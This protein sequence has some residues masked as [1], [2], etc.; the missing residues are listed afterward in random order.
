VE[1]HSDVWVAALIRR[2]ELGGGFATVARKGDPRSGAVLVKTLAGRGGAARL[3]AQAFSGEGEEVWM[4]P[5]D[6]GAEADVD[7]YA[8][9]AARIDPDIWVVEIEHPDGARFLTEPVRRG[10][11]SP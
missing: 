10:N 3:Y 2:V 1:L 7:A 6:S 4:E 5:V 8:Q 9:R 11:S